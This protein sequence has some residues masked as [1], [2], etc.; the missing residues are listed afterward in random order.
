MTATRQGTVLVGLSGGMDSLVTASL[1]KSQGYRVLGFHVRICDRADREVARFAPR[2]RLQ[3]Q[4]AEVRALCEKMDVPLHEHDASEEFQAAV[5]DYAI[6]EGLS[7]RK[8]AT[9]VRCHQELRMRHLLDKATELGI[10]EVATG[11][12]ARVL[13]NSSTGRVRLLRGSDP[14]SDQSY[15]LFQLGCEELSRL[16]TPLGGIPPTLVRKMA[17]ELKLPVRAENADPRLCGIERP[18]YIELIEERSPK[19]LRPRGAMISVEGQVRA[20]HTGIHQYRVGQSEGLDEAMDDGKQKLYVVDIDPQKHRVVVGT[21]Q[22]LFRQRLVA[23]EARWIVPIDAVREL[24]CRARTEPFGPIANCSVILF[25][26]DKVQVI[27]EQP[28]RG[29]SAGQP[30]V[31]YDGDEVLGG[32]WIESSSP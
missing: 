29:I 21:E 12:Y 14:E 17:G 5:L 18:D 13:S 28:H 1:L 26:N 2:C 32:A 3:P 25:E 30:I 15:F 6:H 10:R 27:F 11:H 24:R 31:F 7:G 8:A 22:A 23:A 20:Q 9:C 4:A 19:A 16:I